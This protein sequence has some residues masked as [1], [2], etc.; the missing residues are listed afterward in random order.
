MGRLLF[1]FPILSSIL[2]IQCQA[3]A[4]NN[5][6]KNGLDPNRERGGNKADSPYVSRFQRTCLSQECKEKEFNDMLD[7]ILSSESNTE[8]E[9]TKAPPKQ[10][11]HRPRPP[12]KIRR[13]KNGH[14]LHDIVL[15]VER[16]KRAI[17]GFG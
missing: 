13:R 9:P 6:T 16:T 8:D 7:S 3:N 1:V 12:Y 10:L 4:L 2:L 14:I 17:F 11:P 15:W 5:T